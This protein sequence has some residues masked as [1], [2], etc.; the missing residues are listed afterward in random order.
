MDKRIIEVNGVKL[1]ID[2]STAKKVD[3]YKIGD[4]VKM[5]RKKY[6]DG[7]VSYPAV[8]IGFDNF[9]SKPMINLLYL[10][11]DYSGASLHLEHIHQDT[12]D[13]E[14]IPLTEADIIL[15]KAGILE[16]MDSLILVKETELKDLTM[17]KEYFIKNF[18]KFF[19]KK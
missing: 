12:K 11:S 4:S 6:S 10:E 15:D 17:K 2:L 8:I 9:E 13:I 3:S 16:K 19:E 14:I 7:W 18:G 1:E 5:L